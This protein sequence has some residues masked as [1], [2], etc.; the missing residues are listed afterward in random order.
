VKDFL[1]AEWRRCPDEVRLA[2]G[3]RDA[4]A[5]FVDRL[6]DQADGAF[7]VAALVRGRGTSSPRADCSNPMLWY[8]CGCAPSA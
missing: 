3:K 1:V 4:D 7:A 6:I 8:M 2:A 5:N